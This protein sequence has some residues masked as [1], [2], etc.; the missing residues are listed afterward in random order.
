MSIRKFFNLKFLP[1]R[2]KWFEFQIF[3]YKFLPE[4]FKWFKIQISSFKF[5]PERF[6]WFKFQILSFKFLPERF[7]F[8]ILS[9]KFLPE[10]GKLCCVRVLE[11][12]SVPGDRLCLSTATQNYN[13]KTKYMHM[14]WCKQNHKVRQFWIFLKIIDCLT[15]GFSALLSKVLMSHT[16]CLQQ[17]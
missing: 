5:L 12:D 8:Q 15:I 9:F 1:Q 10:R 7:K 13:G 3:S 6:K 4:R 14:V 11:R 17:F 16:I 2:L